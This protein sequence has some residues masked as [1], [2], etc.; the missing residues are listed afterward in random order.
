[1][2]YTTLALGALAISA[3][4]A[5]AAGLDRSGQST[6]AIFAE[7]GVSLTFGVVK[8][9]V[10]GK[11]ANGN[12]YDAGKQ[13]NQIG[14]TY[15]QSINDQLTFS[16]I[17][18]QPFGA[19]IEYGNNPT[20]ST[21]GGTKATL[22]ST[23]VT[24]LSKYQ[25]NDR[26]SLFGGVGVQQVDAKVN[27]NG[28]AYTT[29]LGVSAVAQTVGVDAG[30]LGAA[31]NG[32]LAA[33][34]ALAA[35]ANIIGAGGLAAVLGTIPGAIAG[36]QAGDGYKFELKK[37]NAP[38][39]LIGAAYEILDIAL[40]IAGTYR[41]ETKHK[42]DTVERIAGATVRSDLSFRSPQ[43]FNLDFQTGIAKDTLLTASYR[44][45]EFGI[46][47]IVPTRLGSDLVNIEDGHRWSLGVARRFSDALVAS[48]T[49]SY[50]PST[51]AKTVSPLGPTDGL[52]G[53]SLG[54]RYSV[55]NINISAGVNYSKLGDAKPGVSGAQ[56]ANFTNNHV[57]GMGFKAEYKF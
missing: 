24:F 10:T 5:H 9:S 56:A 42:A 41:F 17:V 22:D 49:L 15:T 53:L 19:D 35:N 11:D 8:P 51:N 38:T 54:A 6:S 45:T 12:K 44:W 43:S 28:T 39:F 13:Y 1:M 47:D 57:V 31:A 18:D 25:L 33:Q 30:Q 27:L 29:A 50:E 32:D 48:A 7:D 3:T 23:G 52:V 55:E 26:V 16:V 4:T 14:L 36:I 46:L 20:T 37:S 40:R 21:L 2:K 34:A